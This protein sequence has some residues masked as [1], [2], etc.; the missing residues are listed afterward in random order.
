MG[1]KGARGIGKTTILLKHI[2][3]DF[4]HWPLVFGTLIPTAKY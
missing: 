3:L 4:S 1:L 2:K